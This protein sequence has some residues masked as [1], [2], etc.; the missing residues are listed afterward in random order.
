MSPSSRQTDESVKISFIGAF[1]P[2]SRN[3][4]RDDPAAGKK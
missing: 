1:A 2:L 3:G 4:P